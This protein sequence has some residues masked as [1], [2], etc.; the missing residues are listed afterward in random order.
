M[1]AHLLSVFGTW[2]LACLAS[3]VY[4]DQP[5]LVNAQSQDRAAAPGDATSGR[6]HTAAA[7]KGSRD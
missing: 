4:M 2:P 7:G 3:R 5:R 1:F 6:H